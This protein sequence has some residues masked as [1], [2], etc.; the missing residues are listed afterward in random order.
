MPQDIPATYNGCGKMLLIDQSISFPKGGLVLAQHDDAEKEWVSLGARSLVPS[1][2]TYEPKS[3]SSTVH[4]ERTGA[5]AQQDGGKDDRSADIVGEYQGGS[6]RT[7]N[8]ASIFASRPGQV[9]VPSE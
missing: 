2:I 9:E 1:S 5:G 6:G 4:G 8:G 3:N 7:V